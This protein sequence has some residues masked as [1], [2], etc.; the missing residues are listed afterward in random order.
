VSASADSIRNRFLHVDT[1]TVSD[2]LETLGM[3]DQALSTALTPISTTQEKVAGF[4][5]TVRGQML[6]YQG[7]ADPDKL[8]AI[9]GMTPGVV[10]VW[11]GD[12]EGMA[13][14]GELLALGMKVRGCVGIVV[15]GGV[16]DSH[17]IAQHGIPT[18]AK[19]R[20][21]VQSIGRWKVTG[22]QIPLVMP[23]ATAKRVEVRPGDFV[24]GDA[25]GVIVVPA[26]HIDS[27]LAEA[28]AITVREV[29]IRGEIDR[30]AGLDVVLQRYGQL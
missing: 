16:R 20:S 8:Q 28:E 22:C 27:V 24:L 19:Y 25:D 4:A 26:E 3:P 9:A 12:G 21:P 18:Y 14:F 5:Y 2:L 1:S 15:N 23:G 29:E 10:A 13:Y 30:G 6:P 7:P 17:W 11:S